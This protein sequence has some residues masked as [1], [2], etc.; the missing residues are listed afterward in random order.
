VVEMNRDEISEAFRPT[1]RQLLVGGAATVG[2]TIAGCGAGAGG[3]RA[4]GLRLFHVPKWTTLPYFQTAQKGAAK[5][6]KELGDTIVYTGPS[7]P[8]AEQQVATLQNVLTQRPDAIILSAIEQQN[9]APVLKRAMRQGVTVVTYDA[10]CE[11]DAR[12][13][14]CNQLSYELAATTY[15]DCALRDNPK[16]GKVA[17]MAAT[18]TTVNHMQQIAYVK[19][20]IAGVEKYKV[21][22]AGDTFFV[23]DDF[24]KSYNTMV[25]IMQ[26]DPSVRFLIS[27]SAVSVPAAAQAVDATGRSGKV[28]ATGAA[29]PSLIK[30]YLEDGSEKAFALWDVGNLGYMAAYAAHLIKNGQLKV[31]E[32]AT[33]R[34]GDLG[35]FQISSGSTANYNR[36]IIF[37]KENVDRYSYIG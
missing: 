5:A 22:T 13:L 12:D 28:W 3:S 24:S 21:F 30:K 11:A 20:A 9:V 14:F 26:S 15:L 34:V 31:R 35:T 36:P 1:R 37:T 29:L 2:L 8:N 6:A 7:S 23:E 10:D 25:N 16:G 4:T 27:G 17:F 18:P 32:G 19:S 33:F